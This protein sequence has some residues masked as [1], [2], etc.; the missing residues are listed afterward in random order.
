MGLTRL[1]QET[2]IRWNEAED[3]VAIW[4]ASPKTWR[5]MDRL[6]IRAIGTTTSHGTPSGKCYRLPAAVFRW[7]AHWK[8][9]RWPTVKKTPR[10][11]GKRSSSSTKAG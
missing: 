8:R 2:V 1:E 11:S 6:G 10:A 7:I 9:Y 5:K 4:S 3:E